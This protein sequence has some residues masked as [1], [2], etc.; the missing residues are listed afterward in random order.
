M[1]RVIVN[2]ISEQTIPNYLFIKE[3][4]Q[5]GDSLLF[6]ASQ[7][8]SER[9]GWIVQSLGFADI[10]VESILFPEGG[11]ERWE[12]MESMLKEKLY[13]FSMFLKVS[14]VRFVI[15]LIPKMLY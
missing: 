4:F 13:W 9:I 11:E 10:S 8:F 2:I 3:I 1:S 6:I 15:F 7:K 5:P 14:I 12:D